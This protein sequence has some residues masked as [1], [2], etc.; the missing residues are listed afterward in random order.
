MADKPLIVP[1]GSERLTMKTTMHS[2]HS[3]QKGFTLIEALVAFLILSIGM[4]GIASLQTISL[5]AGKTAIQRTVAV[6]KAEE[7]MERIRNN[8]VALGTVAPSGYTSSLTDLGES[9]N[10]NDYGATPINCNRT[11]LARDDIYYWKADLKKSL[12]AVGTTASIGVVL[13]PA[14]LAAGATPT[15]VVTISINWKER[16]PE[17]E[18]M[19]D[20]SYTSTAHICNVTTC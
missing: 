19:I 13:P 12:P 10:C 20:K 16:D 14:V 8:P 2:N 7:M 15:A 11:N 6:L 9:K 5:K 18:T 4:L 1:A 3:R 17:S